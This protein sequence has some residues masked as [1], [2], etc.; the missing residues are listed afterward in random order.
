MDLQVSAVFISHNDK[1]RMIAD[2]FK[3]KLG[4][5]GIQSIYLDHDPD[6]GSTVGE[7]WEERLYRELR[8][9]QV[10]IFVVSDAWL[11]SP[12]CFAE[13]THMR[14]RGRPCFVLLVGGP[15][16]AEHSRAKLIMAKIHAAQQHEFAGEGALDAICNEVKNLQ[17][18]YWHRHD[19]KREPYRGFDALGVEDASVFFGRDADLD[20]L[21]ER[22]ERARAAGQHV[23]VLLSGPSGFGKSSLLRAGLGA[24]LAR[25]GRAW[26]PPA[27]A[28]A[29]SDPLAQLAS[30]CGGPNDRERLAARLD[31]FSGRHACIAIDQA[32]EIFTRSGDEARLR[33]AAFISSFFD[34]ARRAAAAVFAVRAEQQ[35]SLIQ[36]LREAAPAAGTPEVQPVEAISG[37]RLRSAIRDP[38]QQAGFTL[39]DGL[40]DILAKQAEDGRAMP[41]VGFALSRLTRNAK[42]GDFIT[43]DILPPG[44]GV[45]GVFEQAIEEILPKGTPEADLRR[46]FLP[47]LFETDAKSGELVPCRAALEDLPAE[48]RTLAKRLADARILRLDK[49]RAPDSEGQ[50]ELMHARLPEFWPAL[51]AWLTEE[52]V[53]RRPLAELRPAAL[54]WDQSGRHEDRLIHRGDLLRTVEELAATPDYELNLDETDRSYLSAC[55][56][57]EDALAA[58]VHAARIRERRAAARARTLI[59]SASTLGIVALVLLG[60]GVILSG[61]ASRENL[62]TSERLA[63]LSAEAANQGDSMTAMRF[64]LSGMAG[65]DGPFGSF[66][67]SRAKVALERAAIERQITPSKFVFPA[68]RLNVDEPKLLMSDKRELLAVLLG[69]VG[70]EGSNHPLFEFRP[71]GGETETWRLW[72]AT[73]GYQRPYSFGSAHVVDATVIQGSRIA[74]VTSSEIAKPKSNDPEFDF[75]FVARTADQI[76][77]FSSNLMDHQ[78]FQTARIL[79]LKG[80]EYRFSAKFVG[81]GQCL[82]VEAEEFHNSSGKLIPTKGKNTSHFF[83]INLNTMSYNL[84]FSG[85]NDLDTSWFVDSSFQC[86][87]VA[88]TFYDKSFIVTIDTDSRINVFNLE[89]NLFVFGLSLSGQFYI[90]GERNDLDFGRAID[91]DPGTIVSDQLREIR[92]FTVVEHGKPKRQFLSGFSGA[93]VGRE[94]SVFFDES[95]GDLAF[96]INTEGV[97]EIRIA[98]IGPEY[99]YVESTFECNN[100]TCSII[101]FSDGELLF[102]DGSD[103]RYVDYRKDEVGKFRADENSEIRSAAAT[104]AGAVALTSTGRLW[105]W[106]KRDI[107]ARLLASP[108]AASSVNLSA[109]ENALIV[110][111]VDGAIRQ[112][113]AEEWAQG[114]FQTIDQVSAQEITKDAETPRVDLEEPRSHE[115]KLIELSIALETALMRGS[116]IDTI[117]DLLGSSVIWA[118]ELINGQVVTLSKDRNLRIIEASTSKE[119][120]T[121]EFVG[122]IAISRDKRCAAV[123]SFSGYQDKHAS[124][125]TLLDVGESQVKV[126]HTAKLEGVVDVLVRETCDGMIAVRYGEN[127]LREI[128]PE[129]LRRKE[130]EQFGV[131]CREVATSDAAESEKMDTGAD[132][133]P[134]L[135][136]MRRIEWPPREVAS[137]LLAFAEQRTALANLS[138][139]IPKMKIGEW[140]YFPALR[141]WRIPSPDHS[142]VCFFSVPNGTSHCTKPASGAKLGIG[143][144][145][146]EHLV[147]FEDPNRL[148]SV[149][150]QTATLLASLPLRVPQSPF[151]NQDGRPMAAALD[152]LYVDELNTGFGTS[153]SFLLRDLRLNYRQAAV[154]DHR[155]ENLYFVADG[156]LYSVDMSF[157]RRAKEEFTADGTCSFFNADA[158]GAVL[159]DDEL[160]SAPFLDPVLDRDPCNPPSTMMRIAYAMGIESW[161]TGYYKHDPRAAPSVQ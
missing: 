11:N 51:Q 109:T 155:N 76:H 148:T 37:E 22:L 92:Y 23:C 88:F 95:S 80:S 68:D 28:T 17:R 26:A 55:R 97:R 150:V 71:S 33:F 10:G 13:L 34:P 102:L 73:D 136:A 84:L 91:R 103:V 139:L 120:Y 12:W 98:D 106:R 123:L 24:N 143:L 18:A 65:A 44:R 159:S 59:L 25:D 85:D 74:V 126:L 89:S 131:F 5:I 94:R 63:E 135:A 129:A 111:F 81:G 38:A 114:L 70:N 19:L 125:V 156:S 90:E 50:I 82:V 137:G 144:G 132:L 45:F 61:M 8:T 128:L 64:A 36:F 134:V 108:G 140:A 161:T 152:R 62:R 40:I 112:V 145:T 86:N 30:T 57:R 9:A 105:E 14:A 93:V 158:V 7:D 48:P 54:R 87:K 35:D 31:W 116:D 130:P 119:I 118:Q 3:A 56:T 58:E 78:I 77:L 15:K 160:E 53:R 115:E 6:S 151:L 107:Q 124:I 41:L 100:N 96:A 21:I 2:A 157:L 43:E 138:R 66:D 79:G 83:V 153:I 147:F 67:A 99:V 141:M 142:E 133:K 49:G 101:S 29:Y 104:G 47:A 1:D 69:R 39:S 75:P 42:P 46:V 149:D 60:L 52:E 110:G 27:I 4:D 146:G 20:Q 117:N 154:Y 113:E 121:L 16:V 122:K 72:V 127:C 32:E